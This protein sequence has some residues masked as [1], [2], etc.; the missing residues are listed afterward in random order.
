L[1]GVFKRGCGDKK[2]ETFD[3]QAKDKQCPG[4]E[5]NPENVGGDKGDGDHCSKESKQAE[6]NR[7]PEGNDFWGSE[8]HL[9]SPLI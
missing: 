5:E 3:K 7:N 8:F 6:D 2:L 1:Q 4:N 9:H